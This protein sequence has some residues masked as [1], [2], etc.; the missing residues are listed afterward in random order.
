MPIRP[1]HIHCQSRDHA[2]YF[3]TSNTNAMPDQCHPRSLDLPSVAITHHCYLEAIS[4][5]HLRRITF[6]ASAEEITE[7]AADGPI[8]RSVEV[9]LLVRISMSPRAPPSTNHTN[10]RATRLTLQ[11]MPLLHLATNKSTSTEWHLI[12]CVRV[13]ALS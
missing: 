4:A 7:A 6:S 1:F 10:R 3:L 9:V 11:M 2:S 13:L 5:S 8:G 12:F